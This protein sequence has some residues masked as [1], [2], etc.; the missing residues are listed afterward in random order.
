MPQ[1][2]GI[3]IL[4]P[5]GVMTLATAFIIDVIGWI[6]L[7]F[8]LDDVGVLDIAGLLTVG[9]LL[10]LCY[11]VKKGSLK[12]E[13]RE[14]EGKQ[15]LQKTIQQSQ[16]VEKMAKKLRG[17]LLKKGGLSFLSEIIPY[18]GNICPSWTIGA[19]S[20]LKDL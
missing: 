11:L 17:K 12:E 16:A 14:E 8:G 4:S 5:L 18:W 13:G 1:E 15:A 7:L 20:F 19:Y 2:K 10:V 6:L 9:P 3:I